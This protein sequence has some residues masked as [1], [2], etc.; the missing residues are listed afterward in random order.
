[1]IAPKNDAPRLNFNDAT[2]SGSVMVAK[3][4]WSPIRVEWNTSAPSGSSTI[5]R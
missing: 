4:L 5:K 1:M 2:T 3:N